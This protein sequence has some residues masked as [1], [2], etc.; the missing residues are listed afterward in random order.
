MWITC[1]G[2]LSRERIIMCRLAAQRLTHQDYLRLTF[3]TTCHI[4]GSRGM[5]FSRGRTVLRNGWVSCT[6]WLKRPSATQ[7]GPRTTK[8]GWDSMLC[9]HAFDVCLFADMVTTTR[10]I[11][12]GVLSESTQNI[13]TWCVQR[14]YETGT[15]KKTGDF[16][17]VT[18]THQWKANENVRIYQSIHK[19]TQTKT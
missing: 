1:V 9:I 19:E 7:C 3:R 8:H 6:T 15:N 12:N 18:Q 4:C 16:I 13:W 14:N 10:G 17:K 11:V 5:H 2:P